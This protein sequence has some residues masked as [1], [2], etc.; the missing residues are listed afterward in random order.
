MMATAGEATI[1]RQWGTLGRG[2][3]AMAVGPLAMAGLD[4][5]LT[6]A[7]QSPVYWQGAYDLAL[8]ANPLAYRIL[9]RGPYVWA[10]MGAVWV[11]AIAL[12]MIRLPLPAARLIAFALLVGHAVGAFTWLVR[13][14]YGYLGVLAVFLAARQFD[15]W[16]WRQPAEQLERAE[17]GRRIG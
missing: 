9:C 2:R 15:A 7:G 13:M 8:E 10:M 17:V 14:P 1:Q 6:L 16:I 5:G 4:L 3:A 12:V 11:L